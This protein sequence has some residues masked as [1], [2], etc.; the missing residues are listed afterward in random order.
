MAAPVAYGMFPAGDI[1]YATGAAATAEAYAT[2]MATLDLSC[3]FDLCYGLR[4]L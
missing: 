3:I 2:T 1:P 4:H